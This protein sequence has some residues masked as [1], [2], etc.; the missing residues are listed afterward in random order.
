MHQYIYTFHAIDQ[1]HLARVTADMRALGA[2]TLRVVD[3]GDHYMTLEGHH[4]IAAAAALGLPVDLQ[5]I[6]QDEIIDP[7]AYGIDI[8]SGEAN[9]TYTAG[10]IAGDLHHMG[11]GVYAL[12]DGAV[13]LATPAR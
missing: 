9:A 5:V 7:E 8:N 13:T 1:D 4:R 11:C 10:E 6:D 12:D 2:P 3:C